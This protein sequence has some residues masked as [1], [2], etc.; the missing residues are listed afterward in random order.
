MVTILASFLRFYV[1]VQKHAH[2]CTSTLIPGG[3]VGV[4]ARVFIFHLYVSP[5]IFVCTCAHRL[6]CVC[7]CSLDNPVCLHVGV[8]PAESKAHVQNQSI[9]AQL[10]PYGCI[11]LSADEDTVKDTCVSKHSSTASSC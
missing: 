1:F 3:H 5:Y 4:S 10:G 9:Y 6:D 7:K 2:E 11:H 8:S